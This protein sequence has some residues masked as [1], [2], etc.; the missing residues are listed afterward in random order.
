MGRSRPAI[1]LILAAVLL[2]GLSS[3]CA[4]TVASRGA[5][6]PAGERTDYDPLERVNRKIFWFNDKLDVYALEPVASG[7]NKIAPDIVQRSVSNFFT[8]LRFPIVAVN[9]LLQG[10]A[11][12]SASDLGRFGVNTTAGVLGFFDPASSL[13]LELHS[14]DF[15]QTLGRWGVPPGPYLVLP[16]LGPSNPRDTGGLVADSAASVLPFFVNQW[17]LVGA[18]VVDVVNSRSLV[19]EE[20]RDAKQASLDYYVF[21]RNAYRQ[22]R[23]ALVKDSTEL[24]SQDEEDLY[25]PELD[26][27]GDADETGNADE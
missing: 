25:N 8:N 1:A 9:N 14:E 21:V 2:S 24:T 6:R 22:R 3:S 27:S 17:V 5:A 11:A 7:W 15:G 23:E 12:E 13:G 10:K 20:V 19:L 26:G 18:R 16:F 4:S